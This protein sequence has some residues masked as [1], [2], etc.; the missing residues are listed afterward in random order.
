M[1]Q[2]VLRCLE[3]NLFFL[4]RIFKRVA[5]AMGHFCCVYQQRTD[6]HRGKLWFITFA[7]KILSHSCYRLY[8]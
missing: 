7:K 6:A 4:I 8:V 1:T 2:S 5:K 3:F